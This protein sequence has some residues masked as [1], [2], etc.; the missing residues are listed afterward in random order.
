LARPAL[1]TGPTVRVA[2][3]QPGVIDDSTARLAAAVALSATVAGQHP[4]L[5]VWGE[6]SVGIDLTSDPT[7]V[8]ALAA[9]SQQAGADVLVNAD[10]PAT[11]G[12]GNLKTSI[13]IGGT[14]IIG[15]YQKM[16]L[17]P[18]GEY[19]PLR[20]LLDWTASISKA[21]RQDVRRG[22]DVAVLHAGSLAI[23][24]LVCFEST[25]PDMTRTEARLGAQLVVYQAATSSY[26]G[27]WVQPQHAGLAAVRAVEAGRPTVQAAI[28][29]TSAAF[30][31]DGHLLAW[32]P[33]DHIGAEVITIPLAARTTPYDRFGD[34]MLALVCVA[35]AGSVTL[36]TLRARSD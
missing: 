17:V 6:S 1:P 15:A 13:L 3:V 26:Q 23:G 36:A 14:G 22:H 16:R 25:F 10:A 33:P 12:Q 8:A 21:A 5:V 32:L 18:F 20:P 19:I 9:L 31:S 2:V 11:N 7:A 24:P 29:G 27:T 35:L 28:S 4:D 34:W 30:D